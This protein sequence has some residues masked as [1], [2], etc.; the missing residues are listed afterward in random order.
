MLSSLL[1][2]GTMHHLCR[3]FLVWRTGSGGFPIVFVTQDNIGEQKHMQ[4][5]QC[6]LLAQQYANLHKGLCLSLIRKSRPVG[7]KS[8]ET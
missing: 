8:P 3:P 4:I 7:L 5:R 2:G 1:R 6:L